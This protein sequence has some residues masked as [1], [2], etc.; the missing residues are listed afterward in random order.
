MTP[1]RVALTVAD[2]SSG[3]TQ[4]DDV[5]QLEQALAVLGYDADGTMAVDGLFTTDTRTAVRTFQVAVGADDDGVI[6]LGEIVFL[7]EAVF[8]SDQLL[9]SGSPVNRGSAVLAV[10]SADKFVTVDLPA[11][12]QEEVS[13]G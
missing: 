6:E 9:D 5:L 12:D 1:G 4:G 10:A 11:A 8:I 3:G 7:P 13:V 2:L